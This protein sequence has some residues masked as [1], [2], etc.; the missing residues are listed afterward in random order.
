MGGGAVGG[1]AVGGGAVD[2]G[3]VSGGTV[4]GGGAVGGGAVGGGA[5]GGGAVVGGGA[6]CMERNAIGRI[7]SARG[8]DP[9]TRNGN[10]EYTGVNLCY[11]SSLEKAI[12]SNHFLNKD[13]PLGNH[14]T[15]KNHFL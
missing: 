4:V 14:S 11:A 7:G 1:G 8:P 6:S 15:R 10:S 5:V 12:S 13:H 9:G 3:A 2:G